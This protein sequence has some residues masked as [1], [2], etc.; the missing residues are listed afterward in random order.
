MKNES[1]S[2]FV[3]VEVVSGV[4]GPSLYVGDGSTGERVAGPKPWGGGRTTHK[5]RVRAE[6]LIR[7]AKQYGGNKS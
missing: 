2:V 7:L 1:K 4:E 5:F 6:D 3:D